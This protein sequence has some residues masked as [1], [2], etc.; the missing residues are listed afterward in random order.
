MSQHLD[1]LATHKGPVYS[2]SFSPFCGKIFLTCGADC[3]VR[4]WCEGVS[5]PL[6]TLSSTE[7]VEC[8]AWSPSHP[9]V[10]VSLSRDR[11]NLWDIRR[12]IYQPMTATSSYTANGCSIYY[13]TV[14][15]LAIKTP[16]IP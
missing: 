11:I 13:S 4:I 9:T 5:E 1:Q 16:Q 14:S 2:V 6:V 12:K 3:C 7:G 8:A 15:K 10:V